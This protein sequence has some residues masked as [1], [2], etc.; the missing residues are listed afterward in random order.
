MSSS[1]VTFLQCRLLSKQSEQFKVFKNYD[2][3]KKAGLPKKPLLFWSCKQAILFF[4]RTIVNI[5][6]S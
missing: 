4:K 3:L 2:W 1:K 6:P 5:K